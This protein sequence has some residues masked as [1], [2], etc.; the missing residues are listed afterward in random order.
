MEEYRIRKLEEAVGTL[1]KD[2][3]EMSKMVT[4]IRIHVVEGRVKQSLITAG[5]PTLL[6]L[7]ISGAGLWIK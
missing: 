5:L 6:A 1:M 7:V 3:S 2:M 4:E